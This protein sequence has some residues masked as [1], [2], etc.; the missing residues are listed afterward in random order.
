MRFSQGIRVEF[1]SNWT[2]GGLYRRV[3]VL[4]S[5]LGCWNSG[6]W[7]DTRQ[8]ENRF[9]LFW[10]LILLKQGE[11]LLKPIARRELVGLRSHRRG[12]LP[13]AGP[14]HIDRSTPRTNVFMLLC[15]WTC[16][17]HFLPSTCAGPTIDGNAI[18]LCLLS[19][20]Y[21]GHARD[22]LSERDGVGGAYVRDPL[23]GVQCWLARSPIFLDGALCGAPVCCA[24]QDEVS[25][26][27]VSYTGCTA[28][29]R[30]QKLKIILTLLK[31]D[32]ISWVRDFIHLWSAR[33]SK[34]LVQT[35]AMFWAVQPRRDTVAV[36]Q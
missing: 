11:L 6:N 33:C 30:C 19:Q 32:R 18:F 22:G 7:I 9:F 35:Y 23:A 27:E 10:E 12:G 34:S 3:P 2:S 21:S 20:H 4:R 25:I 31:R 24:P 17:F 14:R 1:V 16:L 26:V 36:P 5:E 29:S 15:V 8:W 28:Y 13:A